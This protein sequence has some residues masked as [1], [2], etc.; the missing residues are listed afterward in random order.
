M[1]A[2]RWEYRQVRYGEYAVLLDG[3]EVIGVGFSTDLPRRDVMMLA[4]IQ[5][6]AAAQGGVAVHGGRPV[7]DWRAL[8][9]DDQAEHDAHLVDQRARADRLP[10][11]VQAWV[12]QERRR[13][14][15][16][17]SAPFSVDDMDA[18]DSLITRA[19]VVVAQDAAAEAA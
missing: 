11:E 12:R 15:V 9:W 5:A 17:D 8:G 14:G 13:L 6:L 16:R 18:I 2:G 4:V 3:V 1:T 19:P 10:A 7:V